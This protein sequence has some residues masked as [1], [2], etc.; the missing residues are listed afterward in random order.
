MG[1]RKRGELRAARM[2]ELEQKGIEVGQAWSLLY[3]ERTVEIQ[4]LFDQYAVCKVIDH[5]DLKRN[6]TTS[7]YHVS[8]FDQGKRLSKAG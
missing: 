8:E 1:K 2:R 6:G 5:P 4:K 3:P 7:T